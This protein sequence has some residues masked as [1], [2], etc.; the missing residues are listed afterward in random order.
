MKLPRPSAARLVCRCPECRRH[1]KPTAL[2]CPECVTR[3]ARCPDCDG[4]GFCP[5]CDSSG[6]LG[7]E[8]CAWVGKCLACWGS[9]ERRA[10]DGGKD[11]L[12]TFALPPARTTRRG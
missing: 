11:I 10:A 5:A 2:R 4:S 12:H 1:V 7:C 8:A 3:L 6:L 9:G